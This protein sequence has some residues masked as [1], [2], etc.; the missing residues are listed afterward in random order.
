M[1]LLKEIEN[2]LGKI[3]IKLSDR[4][5]YNKLSELY[6]LLAKLKSLAIKCGTEKNN[7]HYTVCPWSN[8]NCMCGPDTCLCVLARLTVH[9]LNKIISDNLI[10]LKRLT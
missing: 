9:E 2:S 1:D 5:T 10:L 4:F 8:I 3:E 6:S 7:N